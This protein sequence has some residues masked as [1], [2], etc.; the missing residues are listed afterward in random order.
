MSLNLAD[1]LEM[2]V[3]ARPDKEALVCEDT[4]MTFAQLAD[5]VR[6]VAFALHQRGIGPG[7]KVAFLL[8]NTPHFPII[9][10]GILY[11]GA[12]AVPMS[13][14]LHWREIQ[15][16]M[17]DSDTTAIFV[18]EPFQEQVQRAVSASK[19][20]RHLFIVE[21]AMTP[22]QPE[23]GESFLMMM[24][25]SQPEFEPYRTHPD[26]TAEIIFTSAYR[27]KSLGTELTHF[28][29]FQNA[30]ISQAFVQKYTPDDTCLCVLPLFHSFGQTAMLNAPLLGMSKIVLMARFETHKVFDV[31]AREK[32]TLLGVVPSMAH[33]MISYK[34]N[35]HL[36]LSSIRALDVGGAALSTK[37]YDAFL[38]R[39]NIPLL[40]GYGLTE[41]SPVVAYNVDE[42]TNRPGSVGKP[43]F[44]CHVRIQR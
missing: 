12:T 32:V 40:Q 11:T 24:A 38:K 21:P 2:A 37:I 34:P 3:A 23:T 44:H 18:F 16:Q 20:C 26:D 27:G 31:A 14:L 17:E 5:A 1:I 41:T 9:L 19:K 35:E 33:L 36:D 13:V 30:L 7:D 22:S 10:Y 6:R 15:Q 4:R 39:F 43:I 28:N 8:P 29:L 42:A 25:N